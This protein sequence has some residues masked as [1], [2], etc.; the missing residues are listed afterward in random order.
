MMVNYFLLGII[1]GIFE[2]IP[3][4]SEGVLALT[5]KFLNLSD[6]NLVDVALFLHLGTLLAVVIYFWKDWKQVLTFQ[7]K[8]LLVFLII[9]T[10]V[11]LVVGFPLYLLIKTMVIGNGLL[12][13]VG[14]GLLGTAFFHKKKRVVDL[15]WKHLALVVGFLQGLA[16]IPG[17]SRSGSTIFGLSLK[18]LSPSEVLKYS[19]MMS[20]PVV[21]ASS[22]YI[23]WQT[24]VVFIQ[25]W[26][27]LISSFLVGIFGL[28]FL[29]NLVKRIDFFWFTLVFGLLCLLGGFLGVLA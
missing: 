23:F 7:N 28:H 22:L 27:S 8:D 24:P 21:L 13:V 4:S 14:F 16:V 29:L 9:S 10:L 15:D 5:A 11:S 20:V 1:Q 3:I 19:Y 18:N 25:G 2:W 26:P 12:F 6:L 17:L